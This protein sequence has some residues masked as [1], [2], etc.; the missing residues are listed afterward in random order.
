MRQR[1]GV[2]SCG[3][4]NA[5]NASL[6]NVVVTESRRITINQIIDVEATAGFD[7][8]PL[9]HQLSYDYVDA[10]DGSTDQPLVRR[11]KQQVKYQLDWTLYEFD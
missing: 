7:T 9:A 2:E 6:L 5:F 10:R 8:G 3:R 1:P 11:A 4:F